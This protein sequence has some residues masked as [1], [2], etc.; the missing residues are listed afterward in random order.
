MSA[1]KL[2]DVIYID[3][4][5]IHPTTHVNTDPNPG[6]PVVGVYEEEGV[7]PIKAYNYGTA[8][9]LL[10]YEAGYFKIKLEML[11]AYGYEVGKVYNISAQY[12][13]AAGTIRRPLITFRLASVNYDSVEGVGMINVEGGDATDRIR[14]ACAAALVA[15]GLI[16]GGGIAF[17]YTVYRAN[18]VVPIGQVIVWVT[19]DAAGQNVV[20]SGITNDFGQVTFYLNAGPYY[21]WRR[22][23]GVNFT[24]PDMEV[25]G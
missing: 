5:T 20:A 22:K 15:S 3:I 21:F 16:G 4:E 24:N 12:Q 14:D 18:S 17:T 13:Y 11:A 6:Y 25:V 19:T 7:A 10:R 23:A 8:P 2:D 1:I 9:E